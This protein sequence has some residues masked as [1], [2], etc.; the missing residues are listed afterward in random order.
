MIGKIIKNLIGKEFYNSVCEYELNR[1]LDEKNRAPAPFTFCQSIVEEY[2]N[3]Q[4]KV[5][6]LLLRT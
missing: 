2:S 5:L 6:Y 1:L 4:K 3:F